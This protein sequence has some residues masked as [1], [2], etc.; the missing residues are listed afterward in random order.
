MSR[1]AINGAPLARRFR[2]GLLLVFMAGCAT[3]GM[4]PPNPVE[5][6]LVA[7]LKF[8]ADLMARVRTS[9]LVFE[10]LKMEDGDGAL[11]SHAGV[12]LVTSPGQAAAALAE[13]RAKLANTPYGAWIN[14][15]GFGRSPDKIAIMKTHDQFVYLAVAHTDGIN[16]DLDHAAVVARYREWAAQYG[17]ELRGAG[18]DWLS[19]RI[20]KPPEDWAA[21]AR[22]VYKFCPDI[23][24]QG[25]NTV[26]ALA[27]EMRVSN[28]LYL[29]WD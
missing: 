17:L 28:E 6:Q 22:E 4:R 9:G 27:T 7:D 16:W 15:D 1:F 11:V 25:A 21:F 3:D 8:D 20:S 18:L 29:W 23:V 5:T 26:E 10:R 19:A 2:L 12:V 14:D 13:V 24:D